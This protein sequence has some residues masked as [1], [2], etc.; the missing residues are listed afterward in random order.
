[1]D[2][3]KYVMAVIEIPIEVNEKNE[4]KS[5][6]HLLNMT[7]RPLDRL[8]KAIT[9]PVV[10]QKLKDNLFIFLSQTFPD[11]KID[12]EE[13]VLAICEINEEIQIESD[14]IEMQEI[15]E[16]KQVYIGKEEM[17]QS[18]RPVNNTFKTYHKPSCKKYSVKNYDN[19]G[20]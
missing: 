14:P 20:R 5:F 19:N 15:Q 3:P 18:K 7:I 4:C 11:Y 9:D 17:K 13:D 1:M 12:D 8:P 16:T 10:Q 2:T 6:M